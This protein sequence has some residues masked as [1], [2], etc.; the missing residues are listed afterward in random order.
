[1]IRFALTQ[2]LSVLT[3]A[4]AA[5]IIGCVVYC[6]VW[7]EP[8][9]MTWRDLDSSFACWGFCATRN[10]LWGVVSVALAAG[11]GVSGALSWR[12]PHRHAG[13]LLGFG[14]LTLPFG[15]VAVAAFVSQRWV[16]ED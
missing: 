14:L 16:P 10:P 1:M 13:W 4:A 8:T 5:A 3:V 9:S 12:R 6:A 11:L 15:V 7:W 2:F